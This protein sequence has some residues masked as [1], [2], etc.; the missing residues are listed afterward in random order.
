[1]NPE[2]PD[3]SW[4]PATFP[5]FQPTVPNLLAHGTEQFGDLECVVTPDE[6]LT[7]RQLDERSGRWPLG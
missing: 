6:R 4:A 3:R 1:M 2:I 7:Y 5:E